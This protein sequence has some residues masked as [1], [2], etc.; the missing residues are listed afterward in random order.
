MAAPADPTT[1]PS[2][3]PPPPHGR[4]RRRGEALEQAIFDAVL[5]QLQAVGYVGLTM[6]GVATR[7]HTGKAALYRR[8]PR[9]EDLVVDALEHALPSPS[10]LPDHGNV[11][12]DLLDLLRRLTAMLNSPAG[13]ALQC[14]MSETERDES[15][16]RLLHERVKEPRKR[17]FLDLLARG[18]HPACRRGRPGPGDAA[19]PRRGCPSARRLRRVGGRRHRHAPAATVDP[20]RLSMTADCGQPTV[21]LDRWTLP[22]PPIP[23]IAATGRCQMP[24]STQVWWAREELN[25]RPLPCQ[26]GRPVRDSLPDTPCH[27]TALGR[28]KEVEQFQQ[29]LAGATRRVRR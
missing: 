3:A 12:D 8:W 26:G 18:R 10:D 27:L 15:F 9:K 13:C 25:L 4:T 28:T 21:L 16:A 7:A 24:C 11:R 1:A 22:C 23:S 2:C 5:D 14:L 17:M 20:W 19:V 6:E 29:A